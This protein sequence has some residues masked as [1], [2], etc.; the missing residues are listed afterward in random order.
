MAEQIASVKIDKLNGTNYASWKYNVQLV[1]MQQGLW[2]IAN[3]T[4]DRPDIKEEDK[5]KDENVKL[6]KAWQLRCDKAYSI[7]ALNVEKSLQV[8]VTGTTDAKEAWKILK[9]QFE[10]TTVPH[11]VYV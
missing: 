8:C 7:I 3:G 5:N 2:G 4:E 9:D 1:L 10:I 11:V 6:I